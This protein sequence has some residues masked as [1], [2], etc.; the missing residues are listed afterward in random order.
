MFG[1]GF[2]VKQEL[3]NEIEEFIGISERIAVLNINF[4]GY[5]NKWSIVQAYY[6]GSE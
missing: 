3:R 1:V 2:M 4:P 6:R 5:K